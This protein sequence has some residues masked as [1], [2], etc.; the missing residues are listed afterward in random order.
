MEGLTLKCGT[1]L[2]I[3]R[4]KVYIEIAVNLDI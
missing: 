1:A 4:S 3:C 2:F